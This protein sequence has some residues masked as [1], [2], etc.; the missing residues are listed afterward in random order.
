MKMNDQNLSRRGFMRAAMIGAGGLVMSGS[1]R[2][3]KDG[4]A[5]VQLEN[6]RYTQSWFLNSFLELPD[7]LKEAGSNGK[8]FAILWDQEGCP[9]CRETHLVNVGIPE[10][11]DYIRANFDILQLD[12]WGSRDAVDFDGRD[13]TEKALAKRSQVRFTPTIQFFPERFK[14]AETPTG[15]QAEVVRMP[16][17]FRP[18]HFLTMFEFVR[19]K[20]YERTPFHTYL[21][22]KVAA[23][24]A[25]GKGIPQW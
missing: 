6:G 22:E 9:Y 7:D 4:Y 23:L 16:G 17:Y 24:K 10:I 19:E 3:A 11:S 20:G 13:M 15:K 14:G 21:G 18:F 8:R 25:E 1:A 2:A 12:I 5:P